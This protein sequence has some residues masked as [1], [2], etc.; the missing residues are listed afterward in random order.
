MM[1][2]NK[3]VTDRIIS[4]LEQG[5]IPWHKPWIISGKACAISRSFDFLIFFFLH[6]QRNSL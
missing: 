6:I 3:E 5:V 4:Q 2:V 1:D